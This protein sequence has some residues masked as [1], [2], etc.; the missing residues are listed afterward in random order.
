MKITVEDI[1]LT[2]GENIVKRSLSVKVKTDKTCKKITSMYQDIQQDTIFMLK[3]S[4]NTVYY[5][6][7]ANE[8]KPL[9]MI[10][11]ASPSTFKDFR[12]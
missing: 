1:L 3:R 8:M 11:D 7:R 10:T 12:I 4:D 6:E 9:I 2:I 5:A